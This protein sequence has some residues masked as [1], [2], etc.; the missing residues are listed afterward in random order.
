MAWALWA[1]AVILVAAEVLFAIQNGGREGGASY[2][3][4][5]DTLFRLGLL[6]FPTVGAFVASRRPK[7]AIGWI[8]LGTGVLLALTGFALSYATYGLFTRPGGVPAAEVMAW[9]S[10]WIF[11]PPL[12]ATPPLLF[13]LFPDGR[14]LGPRWRAAL[15]LVVLGTVAAA[16]AIALTPGTLQ[17]AP[18]EQIANPFGVDGAEV[19]LEILLTIGWVSGSAG[20]VVGS[21]SMLVR[22]RRSRGVERQQLKWIAG[23]AALFAVA[24]LTAYPIFGDVLG[25]IIILG[26]F[27]SIPIAAGIAILR[28][29]LYDIDV[30]IN[31]TL[32]YGSLTALLG[33]LYIALVLGLQVL[34]APLT[35]TTTPAVALSTLAV[36]ALFGPLRR[37]I[38]RAVDRRFYRSRYDAQRTLEA[39]AA[40]LRDEV[41]LDSLTDALRAASRSTVRPTSASVWL[42]ADR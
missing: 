8:M 13:L 32:V 7:N 28:H 22:L 16:T 34:L 15:A 10:A 29:R 18:F 3:A 25:Q 33:G 24:V 38:Q 20:I 17:D 31:R 2:G 40:R 14:L 11:L 23:A 26:A 37:R 9:I 27:C 5:F 4:V 35:G 19:A 39:F 21:V 1:V 6:V 36:A 42:R 41:D 30:I 12:F